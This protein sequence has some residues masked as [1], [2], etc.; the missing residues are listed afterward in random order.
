MSQELFTLIEDYI[1]GT[2]K[3]DRLKAFKQELN[4][5]EALRKEVKLH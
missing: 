1:Q 4:T 5:N 2:L 3:G